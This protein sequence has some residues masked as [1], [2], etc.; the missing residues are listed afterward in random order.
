MLRQIKV[1]PIFFL[2]IFLFGCA[3]KTQQV[4]TIIIPSNK[5]QTSVNSKKI[6]EQSIKS[7]TNTNLHKDIVKEFKLDN[8]EEI[9]KEVYQVN[10][11]LFVKQPIK[12]IL[13]EKVKR[14]IRLYSVK[15]GKWLYNA[16]KRGY[17]WLPYMRD[18][19]KK[20][21][22]PEDLIYLSLIESHFNFKARSKAGAVGLWQFMKR[23]GKNYG[24]KINW[25]ID[26][27]KD[28][29]KS[30]EA[31]AKYLKFL[32]DRFKSYDL[33]LA[34]YNA[35]EYKIIRLLKRSKKKTYWH[36]CKKRSLK[37]ETKA[38]VPNFYAVLYLIRNNNT[39]KYIPE[40]WL[41][42]SKKDIS[43]VQISK[44]YSLFRFAQETNISLNTLKKL[45]PE[46]LRFCTPPSY[47]NYILKIPRKYEEKAIK[48]AKNIN[49][50]YRFTFK[51]Y[52]IR[53]GDTLIGIARKFRVYP[54]SMLKKFN[55]I[56]NVHRLRIGQRILLPY[57]EE[58]SVKYAKK[59]V[60]R[61][62]KVTYYKKRKKY[63]YVK[64]KVKNGDN[65]WLLAKRFNVSV[66]EIKKSNRLKTKVIFPGD[67]LYI[68]KK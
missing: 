9:K 17:K 7:I 24:L 54:V 68:R 18:I 49:H 12:I 37:R 44:P 39:L 55:N 42:Y 2:F 62:K 6:S 8:K 22:L 35:G 52:R 57:P 66:Y 64:Y 30:T 3:P 43:L 10:D 11:K 20:Y 4:K 13:N 15:N 33:A 21:G 53:K 28:P 16:F 46:L 5:K 27:R 41:N 61:R 29:I 48:I 59:R 47:E 25:W 51:Q 40:Q 26:E 50:N 34:A 1:F 56:R 14:F 36:I 23:T 19:F 45:N 31:A 67:I 65:L 32:Y 38:Y 58:Y 63:H 60:K